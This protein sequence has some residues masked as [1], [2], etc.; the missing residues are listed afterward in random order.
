MNKAATDSD[1]SKDWFKGYYILHKATGNIESYAL[2]RCRL[3]KLQAV[4]FVTG[5]KYII[6]LRSQ[7]QVSY[8]I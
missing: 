1:T 5:T 3:T 4:R 8:N 2:D 7:Q 6:I